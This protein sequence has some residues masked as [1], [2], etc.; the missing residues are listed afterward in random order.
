MVS[1]VNWIEQRTGAVSA[2]TGFLTEDVPGG[3][4]YWYVFGSAT[5]FC[6]VLQ[7]ITGI[8]LTFY[9]APSA[10]TAWESTKYIYQHVPLGSFLISLHYWGATAMIAL[11]FLHLLQVLVWGSYKAPREMMWIVGVLLLLVT[12]VLG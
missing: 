10:A 6:M 11:L 9:Y 4:S 2:T 8:F 7:F 1:L 3:A 12:L 5:L